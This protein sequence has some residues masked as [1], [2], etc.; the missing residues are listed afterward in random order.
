M[1]P[2]V[3]KAM[4]IRDA[5][6]AFSPTLPKSRECEVCPRT[7]WLMSTETRDGYIVREWIC[8]NGH[9]KLTQERET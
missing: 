9:Q 7:A 8:S 3:F 5:Y 4:A 2:S 1:N 6:Q